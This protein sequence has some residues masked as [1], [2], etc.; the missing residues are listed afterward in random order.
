MQ[1]AL[2]LVDIQHDFM[3]DGALAVADGDAIVPV[4]NRLQPAFDR[5]VATQDWHPPGH[6]SFASRHSGRAPFD[7]IDLDGFE[8]TLWPDHCVQGT[9]G[10][11]IVPEVD[12]TRI[13]RVFRKGA[14]L[15]IDSYSGFFDNGHRKATGLGDYLRDGGV[16]HVY[17]AGLAEDV[18]VLFT[19]MDARRLGFTTWVVK[20]AT[21]GVTADG[22]IRADCRMREAGVEIVTSDEVLRTLKS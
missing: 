5:V 4:V 15:E 2:I 11:E 14:D 8:Q 17:V 13:E 10:A 6:A 20:D 21:R 1:S 9:R 7:V 12:A 18:C 3:P 22:V 19:A 16:T